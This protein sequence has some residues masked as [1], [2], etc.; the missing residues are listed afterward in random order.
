M[1]QINNSQ[2]KLTTAN[3]L[4][5][6]RGAVVANVIAQ[7]SDEIERLDVAFQNASGSAKEM[8]DIVSN[9]LQGDL[10]TFFKLGGVNS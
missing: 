7:N 10:Q 6:K 3:E 8:A 9:N 2:N 1:E 5:G 4:F